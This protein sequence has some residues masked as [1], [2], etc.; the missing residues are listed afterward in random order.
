YELLKP[1]KIEKGKVY[2]LVLLLHGAGSRGNNNKQSRF[3]GGIIHKVMLAPEMRK[4]HPCFML[5]PQCR[6]GK[7][8]VNAPWTAKT[9]SPTAAKPSDQMQMAILALQKIVRQNPI[10]TNRIYLT[11]VSMGGYGSWELATRYPQWFAALVPVCGGG[12]ERLAHRLLGMPIWAFHGSKDR[13]VPVCRS[14]IMIEAIRKAGGKAKYTEIK[15]AGH[16]VWTPAYTRND[17]FLW[18]FKHKKSPAKD[19]LPGLTALTGPTSPLRKNERIVF[20]GDSITL[21][22]AGESGFITLIKDAIRTYKSNLGVKIIPAGI[23]GHK[24]TDLHK[25]FVKDV[26]TAKASIVFIYVGINDV[27]KQTPKDK[28]EKL[29]KDMIARCR[30]R[31]IIVILATPGLIGEKIDGGNSLDATLD[32]Y[33]AISRK[34]AAETGAGLCDLRKE[35]IETLKI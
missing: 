16:N 18:M 13:A 7:Q 21:D 25:R 9:S 26:I 24:V 4:K 1:E 15:G 27:K 3:A 11:G 35:F 20:L 28:Y 32:E 14:R 31:G 30:K 22:G 6:K 12:D 5:L 29:L 10:D 19:P 33:A 34:V 8:W 23:S 2:P 17:V